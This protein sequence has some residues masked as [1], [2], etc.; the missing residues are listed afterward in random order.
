MPQREPL[1]PARRP[2]PAEPRRRREHLDA[3]AVPLH[4]LAPPARPRPARTASGPP[5]AASSRRSGTSSS[6]SSGTPVASS[7]GRAP[8]RPRRPRRRARRSRRAT[9]LTTTGQPVRPAK[10]LDVAR[11]VR[12]APSRGTGTPSSPSRVAHHQLVLRV[13]QRGGAGQHGV[14]GRRERGAG[15][16]P[17]TCSWSKVTTSQPSAKAV[18]VLVRGVLAEHDVRARPARRCRRV[19]R[20]APAATGPSA[21]AAWCV[22]RAS[23]PP[24]TIPTTGR[25]VLWM[26]AGEVRAC[27]AAAPPRPRTGAPSPARPPH[28]PGA[29]L[30]ARRRPGTRSGA[31]GARRRRTEPAGSVTRIRRAYISATVDVPGRSEPA[32]MSVP[33]PRVEPGEL[34]GPS[35]AR[36]H[37]GGPGRRPARRTGCSTAGTRPPRTNLARQLTRSAGGARRPGRRGVREGAG[38]AARPAAGRTRRSGRTC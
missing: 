12:P 24:P 1:R 38:H 23:C 30:A 11:P 16:P 2:P 13:Q 27:A 35:D 29:V 8:R 6:A 17:G 10:P 32:R 25:P 14:P 20:R 36:P 18:Q 21:I 26:H 37:R 7:V 4:G 9:A 5:R 34:D 31:G 28:G 15:A 19:A 33:L 22:I 3:D